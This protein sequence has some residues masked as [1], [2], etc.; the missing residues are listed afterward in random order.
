MIWQRLLDVVIQLAL[1]VAVVA[2]LY[3]ACSLGG[4]VLGSPSEGDNN[5]E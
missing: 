2:L 1:T 4:F 5:E 3:A